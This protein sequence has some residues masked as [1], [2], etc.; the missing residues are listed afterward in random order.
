MFGT[1]VIFIALSVAA[2]GNT[3]EEPHDAHEN[4]E[5]TPVEMEETEETEMNHDDHAHMDHSSSG[6]VP[7]NLKVAENPSYK[8]GETALIVDGHMSGMEGAEAT[9][10][11]AYET[12]VYTVSYTPTTGGDPE[13]NHKWVIHEEL[14]DVGEAPVEVGTEVILDADH[15]TGMEGAVATIDSVQ[16]T[17]VYMVDFTLTTGGD[18]ITNHKWVTEEELGPHH[19]H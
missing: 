12:Y 9:V 10:V 6:E 4:D 16:K 3:N 19:G 14:A 17:T 2:C 7:Q 8:V 18:V 15:M 11:G 13:I 5:A 1:V